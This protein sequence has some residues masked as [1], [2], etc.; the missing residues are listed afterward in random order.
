[1]RKKQEVFG[2]VELNIVKI[3]N[4][5][6][7]AK[8]HSGVR[9]SSISKWVSP[10]K[11]ILKSLKLVILFKAKIPH[12]THRQAFCYVLFPLKEMPSGLGTGSQS[13]VGN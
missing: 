10:T 6:Q 12:D 1:M 11:F 7:G 4:I 13:H 3:L 2:E 9:F 8:R 5:M